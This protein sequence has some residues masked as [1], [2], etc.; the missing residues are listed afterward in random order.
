MTRLSNVFEFLQ[1]CFT[2]YDANTSSSPS[3]VTNS[4]RTFGF[5]VKRWRSK[6]KILIAALALH[7]PRLP[8]PRPGCS[9][10]GHPSRGKKPIAADFL[11]IANGRLAAE[12]G[13]AR[14]AAVQRGLWGVVLRDS[15]WSGPAAQK[16][17][18]KTLP[19][20]SRR[21][22][23]DRP[24]IDAGALAHFEISWPVSLSRATTMASVSL[25]AHAVSA[26]PSSAKQ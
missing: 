15:H 17:S 8:G 26:D 18:A 21:S 23:G 5:P 19:H 13:D 6:M 10:R 25:D 14:L 3:P 2:T 20:A 12:Q 4:T 16:P 24:G 7:G 11:A 9:C 22:N 1:L